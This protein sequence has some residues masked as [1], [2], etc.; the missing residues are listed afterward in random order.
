LPF[1]AVFGDDRLCCR[2]ALP[3]RANIRSANTDRCGVLASEMPIGDNRSSVYACSKSWWFF[4]RNAFSSCGWWF[5]Q[6]LADNDQEKS[7]ERY[8]FKAHRYNI[9][10]IFSVMLSRDM[11][12]TC[13]KFTY[14]ARRT[15]YLYAR[16]KIETSR[17]YQISITA[18]PIE[19]IISLI[20]SVYPN[21]KL[22]FNKLI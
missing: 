18:E 6:C 4:G 11:V 3:H 14:S 21:Y 7:S 13:A 8:I 20:D 22:K 1:S 15:V 16:P 19:L 2:S 10:I 5:G 17:D 12:V 9:M